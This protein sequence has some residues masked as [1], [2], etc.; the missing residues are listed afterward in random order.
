MTK[1]I[2]IFIFFIISSCSSGKVVNT[3][4]NNLINITNSKLIV[5][6]TN[7]NDIID[8]LGPPSSK[9]SFNENI[10]IYIETKKQSTSLFKV[11]SRKL[12]KSNVLVVRLNERGILKKKDYYNID[13]M[14]KVKFSEQVTQ[15]GYNKNSYV[16]GVLRSLR[17]KINSPIK[18]KS[19]KDD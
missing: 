5:N 9:S 8:L 19:T 10:W 17:D 4:G 1:Y 2:F 16:Y 6:K 14:N 13:D 12:I 15:S 3:H 11:G 18:R 7:K